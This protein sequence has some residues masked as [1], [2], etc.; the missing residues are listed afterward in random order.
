MEV[1]NY[2]AAR[3]KKGII[4]F[5]N[6]VSLAHRDFPYHDY[7]TDTTE[8]TYQTY[9]VGEN[10]YEASGDQHKLFVSKSLLVLATTAAD[11]KF[12]HANNVEITI[13][14]NNFYEFKS[15]IYQVHYKYDSEAGTIYLYP[16]G[17]LP[18]E[19]RRPE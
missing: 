6:M 2:I 7:H 1:I 19:S 10:N 5:V 13:L 8:V 11:L 15:N 17:V 12:N 16:E 9:R 4:T 3:L 14:A 18:Q